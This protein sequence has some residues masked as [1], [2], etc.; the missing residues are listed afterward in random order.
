V[1]VIKSARINIT[2][3]N[4]INFYNPWPDRFS[5]S[6]AGYYNYPNLRKWTIGVNL[7]F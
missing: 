2:G 5:N 6:W 1:K 3:Q 4:L 7:S